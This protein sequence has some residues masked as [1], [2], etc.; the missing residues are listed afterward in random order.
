VTVRAGHVAA[1][2]VTTL[3]VLLL[4]ASGSGS[5]AALVGPDRVSA[6]YP[7]FHR[8]TGDIATLAA[9]RDSGV[10]WATHGG[11]SVQDAIEIRNVTRLSSPAAPAFDMRAAVR[12][13]SSVRGVYPG[14]V[15]NRRAVSACGLPGFGFTTV[16]KSIATVAPNADPN[17]TAHVLVVVGTDVWQAEYTRIYDHAG[18]ERTVGPEMIAFAAHFCIQRHYLSAAKAPR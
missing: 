17:L 11:Y 12:I 6:T 18:L 15:T 8:V 1:L 7:G 10:R 14:P 3:A 4:G 5:M 2:V 13:G 9:V 16:G